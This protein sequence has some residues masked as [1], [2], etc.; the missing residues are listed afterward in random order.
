MDKIILRQS[1]IVIN[2]YTW[3]DSIV[4]QNSFS[5]M[6]IFHNISYKGIEYDKEKNTLILPRGIDVKFLEN[7]FNEYPV[8]DYNYDK[9]D[10]IDD[11]QLK[12]LPR[13]NVQKEA[14]SFMVGNG[15]Y[16]YTKDYSQ[17]S[18]NL[19]TGKGKT[20]CSIVTAI[21]LSLR[22]AIITSSIEWLNQWKRCIIEYTNIKDDEIYMISGIQSIY[23]L[24]RNDIN[25]YKFILISHDTI[26]SYANKKG[27]ESV[28]SLFK[29][30]RIGI[31]IFDESHLNFDNMIKI[32]FYTNIYKTYYVT[33]TPARS[34][35]NENDIFKLY[36]KNIPAIDLFDSE[37]DPHT[38]YI[39]F[40][41][42][43]KPSPVQINKCMN[44]MGLDRNA[45]CDYITS[46]D[47][48]YMLLSYVLNSVL[49]NEGKCVIYIGTNNGI[50]KVKRW[51]ESNY[52]ILWNDIGVFTS[53]VPKEYKTEQLNKKIILSTTK[54]LGAA[55]D[56]KNLRTVI[57]AAEPFK[58]EVLARQTLGRTRD[59]NTFY[60]EFVDTSFYHTIKYYRA[61]QHIFLKYALSCKEINFS[62]NDVFN[63]MYNR[64]L[65][66]K[67]NIPL[68]QAI[69]LDEI[70]LL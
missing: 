3:G 64:S 42:N 67:Q 25:K 52:P 55:V 45:Y 16:S 4:L 32:D 53:I 47:R 35:K 5:I 38:N 10:R 12:L 57:V 22:T 54:S 41:Y 23:R 40:K 34:D 39:S 37:E 7:V 14:L 46:N 27:W 44:R 30:M 61:K 31:K 18:L 9:Y 51:L 50:M 49:I 48:F 63:R 68:K 65:E 56:I 70:K 28:T 24:L 11:V 66:H 58:S 59:N 62:D 8:I 21:Y 26:R 60:I 13:D 19:N 29:Y 43:S 2:N 69:L 33:A 17:L 15:D 36:F 1:S 6:D 20:Y